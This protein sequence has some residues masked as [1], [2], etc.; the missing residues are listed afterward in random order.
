MSECD[1]RVVGVFISLIQKR[2]NIDNFSLTDSHRKLCLFSNSSQNPRHTHLTGL[3]VS[4]IDPGLDVIIKIPSKHHQHWTGLTSNWFCVINTALLIINTSVSNV[5]VAVMQFLVRSPLFSPA[6]L[7]VCL[8]I[9]QCV[10]GRPG[11]AGGLSQWRR[12]SLRSKQRRGHQGA[13]CRPGRGGVSRQPLHHSRPG[14][15]SP[16]PGSSSLLRV[17]GFGSLHLIISIFRII[18]SLES[19]QQS[20]RSLELMA[21]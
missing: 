2:L 12:C 1:G 3:A 6:T 18:F 15:G 9:V 21:W 7:T 8:D 17:S 10:G 20:R 11:P 5:L 4:L 19:A 13:L 14:P 16:T